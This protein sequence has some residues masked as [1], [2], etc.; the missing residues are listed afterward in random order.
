MAIRARLVD[1]T[2]A[3]HGHIVDNKE[4]KSEGVSSFFILLKPKFV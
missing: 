3:S 4:L 1:K 2:D